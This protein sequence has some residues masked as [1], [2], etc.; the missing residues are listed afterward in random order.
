MPG[1][2]KQRPDTDDLVRPSALRLQREVGKWQLVASAT[3]LD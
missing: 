1:K 3:Y 2:K